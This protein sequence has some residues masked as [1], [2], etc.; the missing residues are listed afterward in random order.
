M[1]IKYVSKYLLD[2]HI[3]YMSKENFENE[4]DLKTIKTN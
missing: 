2:T 3:G 1:G 4:E